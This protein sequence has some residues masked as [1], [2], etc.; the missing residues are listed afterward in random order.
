MSQSLQDPLEYFHSQNFFGTLSSQENDFI[1]SAKN[2]ISTA[3]REALT[4]DIHTKYQDQLKNI[5]D[6]SPNKVATAS[7]FLRNIREN[8]LTKTYLAL[9]DGCVV[10][11]TSGRGRNRQT[12]EEDGNRTQDSKGK[13]IVGRSTKF[14]QDVSSGGICQITGA[15][16]TKLISSHILPFSARDGGNSKTKQYIELVEALF[17]PD[18][19]QRLL[20]NVLNGEKNR[21]TNINR[22][23]NGI[24]M[25]AHV[26]GMWDDMN[27]FIKVLWDT[28][29]PSTKE[30]RRYPYGQSLTVS[31]TICLYYSV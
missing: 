4:P 14:S 30:V 31:L 7:Y 21:A 5:I 3:N 20:Q 19:L 1:E 25:Q 9:L 16:T 13:K 15:R 12:G 2:A 18:A 17:G 28:Y 26:H 27:F 29:N 22:L 8:G 23:D 6:I 24:A 11:K 10:V